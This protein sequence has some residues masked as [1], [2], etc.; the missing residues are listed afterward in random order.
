MSDPTCAALDIETYGAVRRDARARPLPEQTVFHPRKSVHIDGC[1]SRSLVVS[2]ALTLPITEPRPGP[3][4]DWNAHA[5]AALEPGDSLFFRFDHP[6]HV[7]LFRRWLDHLD[8]LILMNP[9]F[10][11]SYLRALPE[12]RPHLSGCHTIVDLAW[13]SYTQNDDRPERSLKTIGPAI[14]AYRYKE[15]TL[16]DLAQRFDSPADPRL[17]RYNCQDTHNTLLGT[18]ALARRVLADYPDSPKLSPDATAF[19]SDKTWSTLRMMEAGTPFSI[20]ALHALRDRKRKHADRCTSLLADRFDLPI[21][22]TGSQQPRY[23]FIDRAMDEIDTHCDIAETFGVPPTRT[24]AVYEVKDSRGRT[25]EARY[26]QVP[27]SIRDHPLCAKTDKQKK[28]SY[29]GTNRTLA[30]LL[31]PP[32]HPMQHPLTLWNRASHAQKI[33]SSYITT[34]LDGAKNRAN[35]NGQA[36]RLLPSPRHSIGLAHSNWHLLPSPVKDDQGQE[37]G[38]RQGRIGAKTPAQQ[39]FPPPIKSCMSSRFEGGTI[40]MYDLSQIELR[41]AGLL[42]GE[43]AICDEYA[44]ED[45][46]EKADPHTQRAIENFGPSVLDNPHFGSGDSRH[47]PRQWAKRD[48]FEDLYLAGAGK[49]QQMMLEQAGVLR[50]LS[51]F[52]DRVAARPALRPV[53]TAWQQSLLDTCDDIGYIMLPITGQSRSFVGGTRYHKP[54]EIVNYPI[55]CTAG[56]VNLDIQNNLHAL[57]PSLQHPRPPILLFLNVYD[58]VF[59]DVA[60]GHESEADALYETAFRQTLGEGYYAKLCAHY[61]RH[62]PLQYELTVKP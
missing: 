43:P 39:T 61:D 38:Q 56:N 17:R 7:R 34:L 48:N 62:V 49:K 13:V 42:S 27:R 28:V 53:L 15:E 25:V 31:L 20:P 2:A 19:E 4:T 14:G 51:E 57:L 23:D 54:N 46:G 37:G 52:Y 32:A 55:Q 6:P 3:S 9:L 60:P 50:P 58:S 36:T 33:L 59:L 12:I 41:I 11:L 47:D 40:R 30:S 1:P 18:A 22:G 8:T 10:D 35:Y 29:S 26:E 45:L 5:F 16:R 44:K 21:E 24:A